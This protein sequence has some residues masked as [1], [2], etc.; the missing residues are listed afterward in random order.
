MAR[1]GVPEESYTRPVRRILI[2]LLALVL[3]GIFLLWRVDSPRV[4]RFRAA[5]VDAVVPRFDWLMAPVTGLGRIAENLESYTRIYEQ[6]RELRR[7]LQQMKAWREAA[8]QLERKNA[9]LLELNSVRLDPQL[10]H[11]TGV[12]MADSG[13]PFR[14]SVLINV[15]L[16]DGL[17]DGWAVMDGLGVVG[18]IAGMGTGTARVLLLTDPSSRVPVLV[19]PSGQRAVLSGDNGAFPRLEFLETPENLRAG[20]RIVTSGDGELFPGGL[21]VG[22]VAVGRDGSFRASLSA[23]FGRLEFLRVLRAQPTEPISDSGALVGKGASAGRASPA[24]AAARD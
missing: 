3:F 1:N 16:R 24:E 15:G 23:D 22:Q 10:T 20:D 5:V 12:V 2:G 4:E 11:V 8:L 18:R 13:S 9:R 6:N 7:E 19:Q 17:Q 14:R 21:L